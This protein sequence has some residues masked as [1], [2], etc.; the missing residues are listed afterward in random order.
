MRNLSTIEPVRGHPQGIAGWPL[1]AR[2]LLWQESNAL[3]DAFRPNSFRKEDNLPPKSKKSSNNG[4]LCP[5]C[6]RKPLNR[7]PGTAQSR[8]YL[9]WSRDRPILCLSFDVSRGHCVPTAWPDQINCREDFCN[10]KH[11]A[12][13]PELVIGGCLKGIR[14]Y[15]CFCLLFFPVFFGVFGTIT[16]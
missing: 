8:K 5:E 1:N 2:W 9:R 14:E 11:P 15:N 4:L 3:K 7:Q 10:F 12:I 16:V 6:S 13:N